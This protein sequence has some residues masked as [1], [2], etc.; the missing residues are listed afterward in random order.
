MTTLVELLMLSGADNRP[1]MLEKDLYDSWQSRM[2]LYMEN[3]EH[4]RKI[5]E[6]I[7]NSPLIW[8]TIEKN[9]VTRT[10]TYKELYATEKIQADLRKLKGKDIVDNAAQMLKATTSAPGLYKLDQVTLPPKVKNT[11]EAHIY[12][13]QHTMEQVIILKE[14]V[15]GANSLNPLDSAPYSACKYVKL[16]QELLGYVRD[17]CPVI[18]N[19]SDKTVTTKP[20]NKKKTIRFVEPITSS[21]TSQ[22]QIGYSKPYAKQTTNNCVLTSTGV[23]RSTKSSRSKSKDNTKNDR[24]LS[25]FDATHDLCF[26]EFVSDINVCSKSKSVKK[27]KKKEVVQIVLW[28]LDSS[29]SKH[30]TGDPSQLT[31]FIHKFLGTVKF[32]N[33]QVAKIIGYGDYQIGNVTISRV[34]Y[35]EGLGHNLFSIGSRE[36]N[37]YTLSIGDMITSSQICLLSKALKTKS[38]LWHRRL[39]H[40]NFGA[41]NH[42][43]K[44]GL[45]RGL[46][47]LKFEKD[48]LYV[49]CAMRKSKK[50]THQPKSKDT[51]QEKLYLLHIDLCG[52]M[53]VASVNGKKYILV[54]IDD[55]SRYYESV[56]ISHQT[57]VA[58]TPQKNGVVE[59][60]SCTL[61]EAA[62]TMLIYAKALL[63]LWAE[64]VAIACYTQNRSILRLRY[65]KTPYELLHDRKP[66]LSYFHV[67]GALCYPTND[68][69]N[70]AKLQ[71]KADIGIFIR[72][73]PKKK[74]YRIYN[75]RTR[76]INETIHVDFNE[77]TTMASEQSSLE[78]ALHKMTHA[79]LSSGLALNLTPTTS[80]I[81]PSRKEWDLVFQPVFDEFFSTPAS[82]VSPV[83][84]V[85]ALA[86]VMSTGTPSSTTIDQDAP[87]PS[88]SQT[89]PQSQSQ[90]IPFSVE[91]ESHDL[92]VAHMLNDPCFGIPSQATVYEESPKTPQFNDDP[93]HEDSTSPGSS[94]NVQPSHTPLELIGKWT[95]AHPLA[96]VIGDP[97]QSVST[98]KKLNTY[99]M[100]CYFDAFLTSVE[101]KNFKDAMLESSWIE[102]MQEEIHKFKRLQVWE[103]VP[104]LDKV[105]LIKL[106]WIYKVKA[107][108][109]GRVLK[110]KAHTPMVEKNKLDEDLLGTPVD[111]PLYRGMIGSLM[112][113]TS[114]YADADH[115][116]C[117]DTRRSTSGRAQ[118]LGDKLVSWSSKKQNCTVISSTEAGYIALSGV[119]HIDVRY[120][121]IKEQVEN[122]IVELYFVRTKYQLADIFT[123]PLPRE[124]FKFLIEKLGM[125]SMSP[126][127]L[128]RLT[129]ENDE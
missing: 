6:S 119:K 101:P 91:E 102:A 69:E 112:Y 20:I 88:T 14:I 19:P 26:L 59:R 90:Y 53:R 50:Q 93:L 36:T 67:F 71:A 42:L 64:A 78:P 81:P 100:W 55:Y 84:A 116:G 27:A 126:D 21:S 86:P 120:H 5:L 60:Q 33:E 103:L 11:R 12:Y 89:T 54:I 96:N 128:K 44:N 57:S 25:M 76:K 43:A 106:K 40:L 97:S 34:Y 10:K 63:F 111:A 9:G 35:V 58:R 125:K 41:I 70:L 107:N 105:M 72:Y 51:N 39:S 1:P 92:E 127:T 109:F 114:T 3:R 2:V 8:P 22:K 129:E 108:E 18:H 75:R 23:S 13:L 61:V 124:R 52:P 87:S 95:K 32:G 104:C 117:Q 122:G 113:L 47:K 62:R 17:T 4:G 38:W 15:E 56:G 28:Y 45:V 65:G 73:T 16:I 46:P 77:L 66:D 98:R 37:L 115:V 94:L 82:V 7:K 49:A 68:S 123:K 121:F 79:T 48:H 80:F 83:P 74:A 118:F 29:C 110:N 85:V 99:V 24:I 31:N 30:M